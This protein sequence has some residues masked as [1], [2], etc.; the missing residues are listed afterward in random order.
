MKIDQ[1]CTTYS[2]QSIP[3][4]R[5]ILFYGCSLFIDECILKKSVILK[6]Y[7]IC[8]VFATQT[9]SIICLQYGYSLIKTLLMAIL[10]FVVGLFNLNVQ[11]VLDLACEPKVAGN[12]RSQ[13]LF[14]DHVCL[15]THP[16][17][18]SFAYIC[19]KGELLM[20]KKKLVVK[21]SQ[22]QQKCAT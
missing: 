10:L 2:F 13:H 11:V 21:G 3:L 9:K 5:M 16:S 15:F 20:F 18:S 8:A 6:L 14:T 17:F 1:S 22:L 12:T 7:R 4:S 19:V